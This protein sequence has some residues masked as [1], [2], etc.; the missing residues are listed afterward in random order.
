MPV[1]KLT[2]PHRLDLLKN[3]KI[4]TP[5]RI[6]TKGAEKLMTASLQLLR[7]FVFCLF[8]FPPKILNDTSATEEPKILIKIRC[9][10]S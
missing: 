7:I 1:N 5:I 10:L 8:I 2:K 6:L 4:T 9:M 3:S